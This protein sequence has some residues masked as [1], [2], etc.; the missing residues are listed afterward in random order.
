VATLTAAAVMMT[1][2]MLTRAPLTERRYLGGNDIAALP[3]GIFGN[4]GSLQFL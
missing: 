3:S 1:M 2:M 4:L